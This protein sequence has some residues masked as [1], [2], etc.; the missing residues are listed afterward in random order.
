M[1]KTSF[2]NNDLDQSANLENSKA[3]LDNFEKD[4]C[5]KIFDHAEVLNNSSNLKIRSITIYGENFIE[6]IWTEFIDEL[7][8][9]T[10]LK[11]SKGTKFNPSNCKYKRIDLKENEVID[12]IT[13]CYSQETATIQSLVFTTSLNNYW[14]V[15]REKSLSMDSEDSI[16]L[17][18]WSNQGLK[19]KGTESG[20]KNRKKSL[21]VDIDSE[22]RH[23]SLLNINS[24]KD[25][26][27]K[28]EKS[29]PMIK[30]SNS[31]LLGSQSINLKENG[32]W[33]AGFKLTFGEYLENIEVYS[34]RRECINSHKNQKNI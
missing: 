20:A 32:K 25:N 16:G 14:L 28:I 12:L 7:S 13:W 30:N 22:S 5:K 19:A 4:E 9:K 23:N 6:A 24:Y 29:S 15:E 1:T 11:L 17:E 2:C 34:I 33:L 21:K 18:N 10:T 3:N 8:L 26:Y 27:N 31:R